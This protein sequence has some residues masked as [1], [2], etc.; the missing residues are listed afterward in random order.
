MRIKVWSTFILR[1]NT[2]RLPITRLSKPSVLIA[3]LRLIPGL[4]K[5]L[6]FPNDTQVDL[7]LT[8]WLLTK[9]AVMLSDLLPDKSGFTT[10]SV[11]MPIASTLLSVTKSCILKPPETA[12]GCWPHSQNSLS[13]CRPKLRTNKAYTTEKSPLNKDCPQS[14]WPSCSNICNCAKSLIC[15]SF[16]LNLTKAVTQEKSI[17][18][19]GLEIMWSSGTWAKSSRV[20]SGIISLVK[21]MENC[22]RLISGTMISG[23]LSWLANKASKSN[24][25]KSKPSESILL[26][27][28]DPLLRLFY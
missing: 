9:R 13:W 8:P 3:F 22:F 21:L 1:Q 20:M 4:K 5:A 2:L 28:Y 10:R 14:S 25:I 17:L 26:S 16:P 19:V 27:A 11:A 6:N 24:K 18:W 12:D 7:S 23:N 15:S